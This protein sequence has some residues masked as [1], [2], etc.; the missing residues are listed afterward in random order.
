M[1]R[2]TFGIAMASLSAIHLF[3]SMRRG[4]FRTAFGPVAQLT[5]PAIYWACAAFNLFAVLLILAWTFRLF[6]LAGC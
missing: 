2:N 4:T 6:G 3:I 1:L 5:R